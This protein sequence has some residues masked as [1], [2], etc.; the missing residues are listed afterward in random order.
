MSGRSSHKLTSTEANLV[1]AATT[2]IIVNASHN[3]SAEG[4]T[5]CCFQ[6]TCGTLIRILK[7]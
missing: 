1:Y 5:R 7:A 3:R 2:A 6:L 4:E